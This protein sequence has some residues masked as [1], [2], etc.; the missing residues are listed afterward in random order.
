MDRVKGLQEECAQ[1]LFWRNRVAACRR[2]DQAE[3]A[4]QTVQDIVHDLADQTQWMAFRNA[5][6]KFKVAKKAAVP[7]IPSAYP[8][9]RN[10]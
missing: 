8:S 4:R 7:L 9:L 2:I 5:I 10:G 6:P 3:F 1:Q